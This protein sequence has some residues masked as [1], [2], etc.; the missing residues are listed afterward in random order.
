MKRVVLMIAV[1]ELVAGCGKEEAQTTTTT[2]IPLRVG[3]EV[4]Y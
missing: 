2:G 1:V 3:M 4:V